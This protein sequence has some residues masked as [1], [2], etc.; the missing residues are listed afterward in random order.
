MSSIEKATIPVV[1]PVEV[2]DDPP[3]R[4][5]D[6][7][8]L[9]SSAQKMGMGFINS[10]QVNELH[11][12]GI[13]LNG[14]A[15]IKMAN[16]GM[17]ISRQSLL[18]ALGEVQKVMEQSDDE[19]KP[20]IAPRIGYLADKLSKVSSEMIKMSDL[21]RGDKMDDEK[22]K[23]RKSFE[24]C[25]VIQNNYYGSGPKRGDKLAPM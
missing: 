5:V 14:Q 22:S 7:R 9:S 19:M 11:R 8:A 18:Y 23:R 20:E 4:P 10:D 16:G 6:S 25:T 12:L 15:M 3:S 2:M 21:V 17:F 13:N 24:P 1:L